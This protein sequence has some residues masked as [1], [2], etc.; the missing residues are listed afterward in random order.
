MSRRQ[1]PSAELG[2]TNKGASANSRGSRRLSTT[3]RLRV[4]KIRRIKLTKYNK[5]VS[6]AKLGDL[7]DYRR[8]VG[9]VENF[10]GGVYQP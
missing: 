9:F 2:E 7:T 5:Q 4:L 6:L 10:A 3:P 1:N 8:E